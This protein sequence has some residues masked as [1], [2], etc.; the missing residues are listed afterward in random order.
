MALTP[1]Q[2]RDFVGLL[3]KHQASIQ[4]YIISMMPGFSGVADILQE[5]NIILWEK[6]EVF[7]FGTNFGAWANTVARFQVLKQRAKLKKADVPIMDEGVMDFLALQCDV[8]EEESDYRLKSLDECLRGLSEPDRCLIEARYGSRMSLRE[9]AG[10]INR[11][12]GVLRVTLYR[13]RQ[14]LRRCINGK[15]VARS[16]Q[17][18]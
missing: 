3:T 9:Y 17:N 14:G 4:A 16:V 13:I 5:T 7:E 2:E 18:V 1:E 15:L 6:R 12:E 11:S 10:E 8:S